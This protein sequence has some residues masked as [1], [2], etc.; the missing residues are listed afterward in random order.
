MSHSA[1]AKLSEHEL[2]GIRDALKGGVLRPPFSS[3]TLASLL[4]NDQVSPVI[5]E[6]VR[7]DTLGATPELLVLLVEALI[8]QNAELTAAH[9]E[10]ELV[11]TG[12]EPPGAFTRDTAVVVRQL[13]ANAQHTISVAGFAVHQG[14]AIFGAL[15]RRM[16]SLSDLKVCMYLNVERPY[17]DD[18]PIEQILRLFAERFRNT[19]WPEGTR[20]PDIFFDPRPLED[21]ERYKSACLHAK[22]VVADHERVFISSANFTEA[23]HERNIEAG[24]LTEDSKLA[25]DIELHF[26][27]LVEHGH[28]RRVVWK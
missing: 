24:I 14:Q 6:L 13:F 2:R 22:F 8:Q 20:L 19:Q 16:D 26:Q 11:M 7:C 9:P 5:D 12:P 17:G 18:R 25:L 21:S 15:A 3:L 23:A 4:A 28:L 27:R 10:I 1:L